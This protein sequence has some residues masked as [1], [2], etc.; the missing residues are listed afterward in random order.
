MRP[1]PTSLPTAEAAQEAAIRQALQQPG[2]V[3]VLP[4]SKILSN[5]FICGRIQIHQ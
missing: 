5:L 3:N 4:P 2:S 1:L